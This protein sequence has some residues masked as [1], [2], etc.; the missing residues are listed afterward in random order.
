MLKAGLTGNIGSGKTIVAGIFSQ[1][2]V[3]VFYADLEARK[4]FDNS[5]VKS[6]IKSLFGEAVFSNSGE[7]IRGLVAEIVFADKKLL[8]EL[9]KIIHPAVRENY[10]NWCIEN[11]R[12]AYTIYEAAILFE[13][14]HY[15]EM[16]KIICVT[17]PEEMRIKRV[18]ERD[19]VTREEVKR[20][21][22]NQWDEARKTELADFVIRNDETKSVIQQVL[23][24][25]KVLV[26]S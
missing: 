25:H 19:G 7:V 11:S 18:M 12:A 4:L 6:A 5:N 14:G 20:R 17:A 22:A 24:V 16:D 1:L 23:E 8:E 21:M 9:N 2:G 3:P 15:K 13:S 10:R 26:K